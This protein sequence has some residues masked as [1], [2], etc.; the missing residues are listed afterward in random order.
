MRAGVLPRDVFADPYFTSLGVPD[1]I[2]VLSLSAA[3]V[4]GAV[5]LWCLHRHALYLFIAASVLSI[6]SFWWQLLIRDWVQAVQRIYPVMTTPTVLSVALGPFIQIAVCVYIW[7]LT[8]S[9]VL[10]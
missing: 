9:S 2:L 10:Q 5:L 8:K 1:L 7:R 3:Q 4:V 6:I